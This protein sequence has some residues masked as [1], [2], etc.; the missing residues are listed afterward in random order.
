MQIHVRSAFSKFVVPFCIRPQCRSIWPLRNTEGPVVP[1]L[2]P[3]LSSLSLSL[4]APCPSRIR[5]VF[6]YARWPTEIRKKDVVAQLFSHDSDRPARLRPPMERSVAFVCDP[7]YAAKP[8]SRGRGAIRASMRR[9][10]G[11]AIPSPAPRAEFRR[12][13]GTKT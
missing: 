10:A 12:H 3:C 2:L 9:D 7:R 4:L 6:F 5:R 11:D 1:T 13:V 8:N